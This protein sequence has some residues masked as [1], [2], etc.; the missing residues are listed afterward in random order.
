MSLIEFEGRSVIVTGA[1]GGLGREYALVLAR[2]GARVLVNDLGGGVSGDGGSTSMADAV[3]AEIKAAG[4]QAAACYDSVATPEGG[5]AIVS[6]AMDAFN[7]V[8]A[9]IHNAGIL[10]DRSLAS[11]TPDE[12]DGV[13][14]VHL[15]GGFNVTIPAF[16]RMKEAAYGRIVLTSSSSGLLGNFGQAN[17]GAAKTGLVGLAHVAAI[18]GARHGILANVIA[19]GARTRMTEGLLGPEMDQLLDPAQVAAMA[20]Y[21]ASPQCTQTHEIFSAGG[22]RFARYVL[23]LNDGWYAPQHPASPDD[24][25]QHIDE[26]RDLDTL[27]VYESGA[28]EMAVLRRMAVAAGMLPAPS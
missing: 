9:V 2:H 24:V 20:V 18:E 12:V 15:R 28:D 8:D 7:Q 13:L 25:L 6:A 23:G 16:A 22:G 1:G 21:L 17:Y 14:D 19:P 11:M 10:R 4:G 5:R 27:Q 3:V 26:I